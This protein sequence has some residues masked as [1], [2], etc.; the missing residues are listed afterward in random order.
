MLRNHRWVSRSHAETEEARQNDDV[1]YGAAVGRPN[2]PELSLQLQDIDSKTPDF[3]SSAAYSAHIP[4]DSCIITAEY[5]SVYSDT[6]RL[7]Y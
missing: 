3:F 7:S 2:K 4:P 1:K 6:T 5:D